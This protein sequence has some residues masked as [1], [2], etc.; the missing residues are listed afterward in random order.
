VDVRANGPEMKAGDFIGWTSELND[1]LL[2]SYD[3][4]PADQSPEGATSCFYQIPLG[5][6][7]PIFPVVDD[8]VFFDKADY[9]I[10]SLAVEVIPLGEFWHG[11][12]LQIL[13]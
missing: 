8:T 3:K 4:L 10:F 9:I 7:R 11:N 5:K 1:Q 2:I 12:F 6:N 13:H